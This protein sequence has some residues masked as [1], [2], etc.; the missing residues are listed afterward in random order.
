L[1]WQGLLVLFVVQ[2]AHSAAQIGQGSELKDEELKPGF[3]V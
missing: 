2:V 3:L 1:S